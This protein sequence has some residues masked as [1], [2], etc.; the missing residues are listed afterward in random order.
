MGVRCASVWS[1]TQVNAMPSGN[2]EAVI[3][4]TPQ[5]ILAADSAVVS[6]GWQFTLVVGTCC[7]S[8]TFTIRRGRPQPVPRWAMAHGR[9]TVTATKNGGHHSGSYSDM[10]GVTD[11]AILF[12]Y[13]AEHRQQRQHVYR[14]VPAGLRAVIGAGYR[15]EHGR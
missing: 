13:P 4:V 10:A 8:V 14:C 7:T 1:N 2:T 12:D 9:Q 11:F 6:L 5:I 15:A 3:L